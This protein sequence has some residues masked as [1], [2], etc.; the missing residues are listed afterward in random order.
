MK[1][2]APSKTFGDIDS[3]VPDGDDG[4]LIS[5]LWPEKIPAEVLGQYRLALNFHPA[6]LPEFRGF[7]PYT[8]GI[9]E[10]VRSWA[11][12]CHKM[13]GQIDAGDI[14]MERRYHCFTK[15]HT[16]ATMRAAA[17]VMLRA[18]LLDVL[19]LLRSGDEL[20][21]TPQDERRARYYS[22]RDFEMARHAPTLNPEV[23][24]RAF[25]C[26]PHDGWAPFKDVAARRREREERGE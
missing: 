7:A 9:L 12:T 25:H 10:G 26:P 13:T 14:L 18:L 2:L 24:T 20:V 11:V 23:A 15:D 6:P 8:W 3:L 4:I 19:A 16:A 1:L 17:H 5:Y 21:F 22:R